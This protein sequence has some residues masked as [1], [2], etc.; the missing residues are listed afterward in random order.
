MFVQLAEARERLAQLKK[1]AA[2]NE[3]GAVRT[4]RGPCPRAVSRSPSAQR[5]RGL[6]T[7]GC[8]CVRASSVCACVHSRS[9]RLWAAPSRAEETRRVWG[10][11]TPMRARSS[12]LRRPIRCTPGA[13][14]VHVWRRCRCRCRHT[15][16]LSCHEHSPHSRS[17][18]GT[19]ML[20][21][22]PG[23]R[24]CVHGLSSVSVSVSVSAAEA[25]W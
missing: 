17:P 23:V 14:L 6:I 11:P 22:G 20:A 24:A 4:R 9:R 25:W 10:T 3:V 21:A 16:L 15:Q 1:L 8:V 19:A 7:S 5:R 13:V 12:T 2:A 18:G